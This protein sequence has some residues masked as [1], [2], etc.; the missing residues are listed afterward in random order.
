MT[1]VARRCTLRLKMIPQIHLNFGPTSLDR[2]Y[3]FSLPLIPGGLFTG[4]LL[5]AHPSFGIS[6]RNAL[7]LSEPASLLAFVFAAYVAGFVLFAASGIVTGIVSGIVQGVVFRRW[8]PMRWSRLLSQSSVWRTVAS[9]FLGDKLR[10]NFPQSE[11]PTSVLEKITASIKQIGEK[12]QQDAIWEEWYRVLQDYLL[13]DVP[14]ISNDVAFTWVALQATG[15]AGI[16]LS[17][18]APPA[19][20]WIVYL[21]AVIFISFGSLFPFLTT[22]SYLSS[23][24]L[25]YWDFTAKLLAEAREGD[26]KKSHAPDF[27]GSNG[28]KVVGT[29][30]EQR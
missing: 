24:R 3:Q 5:F 19:R 2:V 25:T 1:L 7:G 20:H 30:V 22:L 13:R 12:T 29:T 28:E 15:W 8:V 10:P 6:L 4:G 16:A 17:F 11:P 9:E 23:E 26:D 27:S 21:L 18:A 14:M